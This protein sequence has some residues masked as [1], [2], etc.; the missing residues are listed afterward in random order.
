M[1]SGRWN[2]GGLF[3]IVIV[4]IEL[5]FGFD[6][7][8]FLFFLFIYFFPSVDAKCLFVINHKIV[9]VFSSRI[10]RKVVHLTCPRWGV[11]K[12]PYFMQ[13]MQIMS[14]CQKLRS[15]SSTML[16]CVYFKIKSTGFSVEICWNS[17][18]FLSF[19]ANGS[20]FC[21]VKRVLFI[22]ERY[23]KETR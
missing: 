22:K 7:V 23:D 15:E 12:R 2:G 4:N 16:W 1:I 10:M 19:W 13:I 20:T 11:F 17:L 9:V 14:H 18:D 8:L 5:D 21:E 3:Y 6:G